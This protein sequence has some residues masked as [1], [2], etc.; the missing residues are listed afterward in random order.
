MTKLF[1]KG[2]GILA[3]PFIEHT[4]QRMIHDKKQKAFSYGV[5]SSCSFKNNA[6]R[7]KTPVHAENTAFDIAGQWMTNEPGNNKAAHEQRQ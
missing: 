5:S 7:H 1:L 3:L 4:M 2:Q 6:A